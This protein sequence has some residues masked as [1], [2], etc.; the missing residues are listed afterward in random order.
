MRAYCLPPVQNKVSLPAVAA[1]CLSAL[2]PASQPGADPLRGF[3]GADRSWYLSS[4]RAALWLILKALSALRPGTEVVIP[5]YTCP[6]VP[7]AIFK[8]GLK[9]VLADV[10]LTDF[11]FDAD[12]LEKKIGRETLAVVAVHLFGYPAGLE[13]TMKLC[14]RQ[15]VFLVEDAAQAF[16]NTLPDSPD[17]KLGLLA[18]ASF[19]SF[20]RGKPIGALHGGLVVA[21]SAEICDRADAVYAALEEFSP[22]GGLSALAAFLLSVSLSDPRLYW[23]PQAM[24][25]LHLGET[26]FVPDFPI[27]KGYGR[28]VPFFD[29]MLRSL[30]EEKR[31]R[32]ENSSWYADHLPRAFDC[33]LP[34]RGRYPY[35][36]YPFLVT[37]WRLRDKLLGRLV[38]EGSGAGAFYPCPLNELP[39][40]SDRL[41]D[42][43]RYGNA[44]RLARGLITLP[45]HSGVTQAA[46]VKICRIARATFKEARAQ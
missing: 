10:N 22:V 35:L 13:R 38:S 25:F 24:P 40:L 42:R 31:I 21:R 36:R 41:E 46:R 18:D 9:P 4:G 8:A 43:K 26:H 32:E 5:A 12:D 7:A 29:L 16:G 34:P 11:G 44:R 19:Y 23:M 3:L 14:R 27:K 28:A 30:Q 17:M 33:D 15:D 45:V 2:R 20:G 6:A 39:L 37:D 1:A